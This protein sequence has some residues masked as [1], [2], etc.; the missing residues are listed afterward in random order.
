MP[1]SHAGRWFKFSKVA[2]PAS[3]RPLPTHRHALTHYAL[4]TCFIRRRPHTS[5]QQILFPLANLE[6]VHII[7]LQSVGGRMTV[8]RIATGT[9]RTF[10]FISSLTTF[11]RTYSFMNWIVVIRT[12]ENGVAKKVRPGWNLTSNRMFTYHRLYPER[13]GVFYLFWAIT[14]PVRSQPPSEQFLVVFEDAGW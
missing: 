11:K 5:L 7:R 12:R 6:S 8:L 14:L 2:E 4:H 13:V 3:Q 9:L 1:I 10:T